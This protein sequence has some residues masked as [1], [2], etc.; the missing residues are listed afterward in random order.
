M[1]GLL[2]IIQSSSVERVLWTKPLLKTKESRFKMRV[3]LYL[4]VKTV[5]FRIR[6]LKTS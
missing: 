5:I 2:M 3:Y 6:R 4:L 1:L